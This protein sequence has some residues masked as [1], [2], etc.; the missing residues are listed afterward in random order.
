VN[1]ERKLQNERLNDGEIWK[2][3]IADQPNWFAIGRLLEMVNHD[4]AALSLAKSA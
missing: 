2:Q 4:I 3:V 1:V